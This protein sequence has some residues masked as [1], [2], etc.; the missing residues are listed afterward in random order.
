MDARWYNDLEFESKLPPYFRHRIVENHF[1]VQAMCFEPQL[2]RARIIMVKYFTILVLLDDT[3]DR[4][5]SLPE[6][7]GLANSLERYQKI[8]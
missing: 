2:S 7:E 4:Y 1:F 8:K 3:F 5:A 6:A